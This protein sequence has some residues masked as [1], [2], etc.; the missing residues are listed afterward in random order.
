MCE[1]ELMDFVK[2][3]NEADSPSEI[4]RVSKEMCEFLDGKITADFINQ[5]HGIKKGEY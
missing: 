4:N 2:K 5:H 3:F 1:A